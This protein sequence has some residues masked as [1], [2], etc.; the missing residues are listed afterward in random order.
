M[1][2][3]PRRAGEGNPAG[4]PAKGGHRVLISAEN[5]AYMAWQCQLLHYSCVTRLGRTPLIVVHG[6]PDAPLSPGFRAIIRAGGLVR[7][8]PDYGVTAAGAEYPPRNTPA[9]LL[10]A[11]EM[12]YFDDEFFVLCDPDIIFVREPAFAE[13][14]AADHYPLALDFGH[15]DVR[16]AA[17]RYGVSPDA[18]S[19]P[20]LLCGVPHVIPAADAA[21]LAAAWIEAVDSFGRSRLWEISMYAFGF[22]VLKLGMGLR[23]TRLSCFNNRSRDPLPPGASVIHYCLGDRLWTKRRYWAEADAPHVWETAAAAPG[24]TVLGEILSQLRAARNFYSVTDIW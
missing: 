23:L 8:A 17:R 7:R 12:N 4:G 10:H 9:T 5:N 1:D 20:K 24:G 16:A 19:R 13:T 18:L 2:L 21:R 22:A 3:K 11:A 14:L 15:R 6:P